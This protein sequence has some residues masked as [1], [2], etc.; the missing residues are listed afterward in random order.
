MTGTTSPGG[1]E[2][3]R[4]GFAKGQVIQEWGY[5]DDVDVALRDGLVDL[6]I[7]LVDED[8]DELSDSAL[9]WWRSDEGDA[10]DLEDLLVDV[11]SALDDGG[12][13]WLLVPKAG[14]PGHVPPAELGE[15]AQTAGLQPTSSIAAAPG[16]LG[17]RL[18]AKGRGR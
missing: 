8:Y 15:S 18:V 16:W 10:T 17:M 2:A 6:G 9:V 1:S 12:L 11:V 5:D 4:F 3:G 13:V 14:R 7:E